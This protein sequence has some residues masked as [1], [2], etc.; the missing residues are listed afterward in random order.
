MGIDYYQHPYLDRE[1]KTYVWQPH[2]L[3]GLQLKNRFG[4]IAALTPKLIHVNHKQAIQVV[5]IRV[6]AVYHIRVQGW[7]MDFG[8]IRVNHHTH[9]KDRRAN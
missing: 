6:C 9:D 4:V 2:N 3:G 1:G 7:G 5:I 8:R